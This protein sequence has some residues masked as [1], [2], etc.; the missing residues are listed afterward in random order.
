MLKI[1]FLLM[2][3]FLPSFADFYYYKGEKRYI[4]KDETSNKNRT[5]SNYS[6]YKTDANQNLIITKNIIVCFKD[7]SIKNSIENRFNLKEIKKL[8]NDT[9][10]YETKSKNVLNTANSIY[11]ENGIKYSHPDFI[12]KKRVRTTDPL[13]N[14]A[15]HLKNKIYKRNA[16]IN[17]ESAWK[18]SKGEGVIVAVYDEGIDINHEDLRGNI[19]G[20]NN[21]NDQTTTFPLP[22]PYASNKSIH[23]NWHGT[24]CAGLIAA[25]ENRKGSVGVAP[26]AKILAVRYA[27]GSISQDIE[28]YNWM[29]AHGASIITNSWGTYANMDAYN[30]TFKKHSTQGRNGK[31][32][33][34]F[35]AAGN[36]KLNLDRLDPQS[37]Q[38]IDDE[39]ESPY[40]ISIAASTEYDRI[41]SYSNYGSSIDF[42]AP[43]GGKQNI[44]TTD[45]SENIDKRYTL[46]EEGRYNGYKYG[47][48]NRNFSGTSAAS[49]IAAGVAALILSKNPTLSKDDVIKILKSSAKKIGKYKYDSNG[50]NDHW[51]YG[52]I[53]AGAALKIAKDYKSSKITNFSSKM[54]QEIF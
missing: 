14:K 30:D 26:K 5:I 43:G 4:Q 24:A 21:F 7:I 8:H 13:Y 46:K 18:Y 2:I 35:F 49:P 31:G 39:S 53:D 6:L 17:V 50:R 10:V 29:V 27:D 51:G 1:L 40:V 22:S 32:I 38:E 33:L 3:S 52:R 16:D 12:V 44:V 54:F 23:N 41:A 47:N 25:E 15:W 20:F 9:F 36:D 42:T 45:A 11:E 28:A 34:I 37:H 48:Y 19:I